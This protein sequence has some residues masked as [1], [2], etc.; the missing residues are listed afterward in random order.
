M[1]DESPVIGFN[2]REVVVTKTKE[3][4]S[5]STKRDYV[6]EVF[7]DSSQNDYIYEKSILPLMS[8]LFNG[9]SGKRHS[10]QLVF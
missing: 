1:L 7:N 4:Y 10:T 6:D 8:D 3:V 2:R 5:F 9:Y